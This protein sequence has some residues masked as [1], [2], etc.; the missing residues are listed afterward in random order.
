MKTF[1]DKIIEFNKLLYF[2]GLLPEGIRIMNPF[3]DNYIFQ[4]SSSFYRK[5]YNDNKPRHLILGINPGRFGAGFTGVPFTDTKR[6]T[7]ECGLNYSGRQTHEPSSVFVYEVIK[8]YGGP[9]QFYRDFYI[10]SVCPLGFTH[11]GPNGKEINYNY[12]DSSELMSAVLDFIVE[13]IRIQ[14]E[15]GIAADVCFCFGTGKNEKFLRA[16]NERH[17]FF[18]KIIAL[19][20]PRFVM[21]YKSRSRQ[22]YITKYIN[23][24]S[25]A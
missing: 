8:E 13:S 4:V 21:Q 14:I 11:T 15:F 22:V 7:V 18:N 3:R 6:L 9:A 20:H 24:L 19:E 25:Q 5:Y 2:E 1:A 17:G 10:T 23:A 16:L 12:Y